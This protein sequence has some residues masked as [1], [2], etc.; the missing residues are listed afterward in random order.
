MKSLNKFK[1]LNVFKDSYDSYLRMRRII[2]INKVWG[3]YV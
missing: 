1:M 3:D 2:L